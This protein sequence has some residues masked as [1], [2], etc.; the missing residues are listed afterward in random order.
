MFM[1]HS[2][3]EHFRLRDPSW[4]RIVVDFQLHDGS[5][6]KGAVDLHQGLDHGMGLPDQLGLLPRH[7]PGPEGEGAPEDPISPEG[8]GEGGRHG[9]DLHPRVRRQDQ[10]HRRVRVRRC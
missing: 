9:G 5:D 6:R 2:A 8:D 7:Q 1:V 4:T 10:A 3:V